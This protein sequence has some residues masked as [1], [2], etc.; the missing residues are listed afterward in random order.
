MQTFDITAPVSV[1][2]DVPA[3]RVQV[4][5][6][7]RADATVEVRP[8]DASKGRDVK[9]AEL[10]GAEYA[11]GA[12]RVGT[13][14]D[15]NR[16]TG[17]R[18]SVEVTVQL[19]AGSRVE[20]RA[21]AAEFRA[22]GRLG[23]IVLEGAH[24]QIKIDEAASVRLTAIDGD[25]EI[26]RLGG[27]AEISTARGDI[28][29]TQALRGT[30]ALRTGSGDISIGAA[31]GVSASLNAGTT[32]GRINNTLKNDGTTALDIHATTP[33]GDITAHTL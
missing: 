8:V 4:I 7:D 15:G 12:L 22:V 18:G 23:D 27:P 28:R 26:G 17:P 20:A 2:L 31:P 19:P 14:A 21:A 13:P 24:R 10:T 30:V 9:A 5:A 32:H 3:G 1:V 25:I 11:D 33:M 6:G 29:I 16:Y